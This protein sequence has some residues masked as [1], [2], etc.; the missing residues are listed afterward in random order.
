MDE[1]SW[2]VVSLGALLIVAFAWL[3][4]GLSRIQKRKSRWQR[5][6]ELEKGRTG[7]DSRPT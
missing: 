4:H 2:R 3:A 6:Q 1:L 7:D 5:L